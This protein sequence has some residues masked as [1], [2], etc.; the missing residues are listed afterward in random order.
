MP[1]SFP[2]A[3]RHIAFYECRTIELR[4]GTAL[5]EGLTDGVLVTALDA[6]EAAV[7]ERSRLLPEAAVISG[8]RLE[9][10]F[11]WLIGFALGVRGFW[12]IVFGGSIS[13]IL[14]ANFPLAGLISVKNFR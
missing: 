3:A 4:G 14:S 1:K 8:R 12:G 7:E 11:T 13:L 6:L 9:R 2:S 10:Q 5:V